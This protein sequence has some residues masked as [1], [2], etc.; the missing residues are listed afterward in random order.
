M[1]LSPYLQLNGNAREAIEHIKSICREDLA[2]IAR[3][4]KLLLDYRLT[5]KHDLEDED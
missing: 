3:E 1:E 4:M 2:E 5:P